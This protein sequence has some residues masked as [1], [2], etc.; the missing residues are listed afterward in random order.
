MVKI[1]AIIPASL[2]CIVSWNLATAAPIAIPQSFNPVF[3]GVNRPATANVA[4]VK[5]VD[6]LPALKPGLVIPPIQ[7]PPNLQP[8][9]L[10]P[11][12]RN[13]CLVSICI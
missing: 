7:L 9:Q 1:F 11:P 2:A 8:G 6:R 3:S 13:D 5:P 4:Q 10:R 12:I